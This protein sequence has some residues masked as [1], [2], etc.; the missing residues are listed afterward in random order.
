VSFQA[1]FTVHNAT[2]VT[3]TL[4]SDDLYVPFSIKPGESADICANPLSSP[5]LTLTG[6]VDSHLRGILDLGSQSLVARHRLIPC[7]DMTSVQ[8]S[9]GWRKWLFGNQKAVDKP[10]EY[11]SAWYCADNEKNC[12]HVDV[13]LG[14]C[15]SIS[16]F[17]SHKL[18]V[19]HDLAVISV[20]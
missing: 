3:L 6:G 9:G 18:E 1:P 16:N 5:S 10:C 17:T 19:A 7:S 4:S 15:A 12:S 8:P 20:T 11:L 13:V 2:H 14:P